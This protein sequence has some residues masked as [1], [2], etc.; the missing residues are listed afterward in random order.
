MN[1]TDYMNRLRQELEGLPADMLE[2]TMWAYES[3]FVDGM[4]AGRSEADIAAALPPPHLVAAQQRASLRLDALKK[5]L[6]PT[7]LASLLV[8]LLG[9]LVVN[10]LMLIPAITYTALLFSAYLVSLGLYVTGIVITAASLSGVPQLHVDFPS[11]HQHYANGRVS[12]FAGHR[13]FQRHEDVTVEITSSGIVVN[14]GENVR[15]DES[16]SEASDVANSVASAAANA[17]DNV[18]ASKDKATKPQVKIDNRLLPMNAW[19]G[20]GVLAAGIFLFL[21]ALV[22]SR[23]SLIGFR[24]YLR[25]NISLLRLSAAS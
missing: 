14:T 16:Q 18:V 15:A 10:L 7:N 4:I 17:V 12:E 5:N 9:V 2:H 23:Y 24:R 13:R 6:S 8:A 21:L 11:S 3:K 1:K 25:W 19:Q 22:A 20:L